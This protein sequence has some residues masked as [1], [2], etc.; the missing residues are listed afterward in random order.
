MAADSFTINFPTLSKDPKGQMLEVVSCRDDAVVTPLAMTFLGIKLEPYGGAHGQVS[1]ALR[2][3]I[4]GSNVS[5]PV[6]SYDQA[7][8]VQMTPAAAEVV[9]SNDGLTLS[10]DAIDK[11]YELEIIFSGASVDASSGWL[12]TIYDGSPAGAN[13]TQCF[14]NGKGRNRMLLVIDGGIAYP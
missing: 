11:T 6:M 10:Y 2:D 12:I 9:N 13:F 14:W 3:G 4:G 1:L 8:E 7:V 5:A